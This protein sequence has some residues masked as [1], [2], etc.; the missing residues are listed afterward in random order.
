MNIDL[1]FKLLILYIKYLKRREE[2]SGVQHDVSELLS[3]KICTVN[4]T[5][6]TAQQLRLHRRTLELR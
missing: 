5:F 1:F 3:G 6:T 2:E 4:N